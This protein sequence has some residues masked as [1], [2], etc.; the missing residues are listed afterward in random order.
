[1]RRYGDERVLAEPRRSRELY[2]LTM[3]EVRR[4]LYDYISQR[5]PIDAGRLFGT[6]QAWM[7]RYAPL[8]SAEEFTRFAVLMRDLAPYL[9]LLIDAQNHNR[10]RGPTVGRKN[11]E[12]ILYG[13]PDAVP[14]FGESPVAM[15]SP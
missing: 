12:L 14:L 3:L 5:R 10:R 6:R 8:M 15:S 9:L 4:V 13:D 7:A 11:I 1:M 2:D